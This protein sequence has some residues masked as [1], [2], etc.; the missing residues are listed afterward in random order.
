[1]IFL[2]A[3]IVGGLICAVGQLLIDLTKLTPGK[4]LV[5]FVIA[6]VALG[7]IGVY[8]P[9]VEFAGAGATVPLT[10]FGNVLVKGTKEAIAQYGLLGVL[11]GPMSAGAAGIMAALISGI[12]VSFLTK[13]KQK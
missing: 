13:P 12:V 7:A 3:F 9:L 1:M 8:E 11:T 2:K 6:G 5:I 4:I 10:G